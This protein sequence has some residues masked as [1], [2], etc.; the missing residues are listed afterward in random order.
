MP[1]ITLRLS[2]ALDRSVDYDESLDPARAGNP[3]A[4]ATRTEPVSGSAR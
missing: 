4:R 2:E 1:S 3:A